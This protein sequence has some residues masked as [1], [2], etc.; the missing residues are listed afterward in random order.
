MSTGSKMNTKE[1]RAVRG[2][3]RSSLCLSKCE[4]SM[5]GK[6]LSMSGKLLSMSGM[7]GE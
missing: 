6:L 3:K 7:S 5:S 4:L 1:T 2:Q